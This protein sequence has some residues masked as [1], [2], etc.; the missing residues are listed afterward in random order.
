MK[1]LAPQALEPRFPAILW[2]RLARALTAARLAR[3]LTALPSA[4]HRVQ[5]GP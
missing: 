5:A 2:A 4:A 3:A 1:G